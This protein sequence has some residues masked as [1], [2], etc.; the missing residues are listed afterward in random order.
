MNRVFLSNAKIAAAAAN[1]PA[2]Y[3]EEFE[4]HVVRREPS[5]AWVD[6]DSP[7]WRAMK[8][9]YAPTRAA[10]QPKPPTKK[11]AAPSP[12]V[13]REKWPAWISKI[14]EHAAPPD[15]G[16]GDTVER[17]AGG[18]GKLFK[19]MFTKITGRDCGCDGRRDSLNARYPYAAT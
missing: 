18:A 1:R 16:V 11:P 15:R 19:A 9:R 8:E 7:E 10:E 3:L 14:A 6:E 5:G 17:M 13:P 2:G 4:Q 12:A